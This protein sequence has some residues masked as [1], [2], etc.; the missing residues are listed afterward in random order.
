M[1]PFSG[2][3]AHYFQ[4]INYLKFWNKY[5]GI[6]INFGLERLQYKRI[7]FT[8]VSGVITRGGIGNSLSNNTAKQI[9]SIF[10]SILSTHELGYGA[11]TYKE[12]FQTE[13]A[14]QK[15]LCTIPV[16]TL[17]YEDVTLGE[18]EIGAFCLDSTTLISITALN[19]QSSAADMTRLL[20]YMR[21]TRLHPGLLANF[22]KTSLN[23][24]LLTQ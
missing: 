14:H 21:Q 3:T 16:V 6:L 18:P 4:L 19:E 17:Q 22:G 20:G 10:D 9:D 7:P 23:L 13:C 11:E 15:I 2:A 8:P 12:L 5:L 24:R 1:A